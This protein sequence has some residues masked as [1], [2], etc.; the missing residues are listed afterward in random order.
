MFRALHRVQEPGDFL[1]T[2]NN[3]EFLGLTAGWDV[4]FDNPRPLEGDGIDKPVGVHRDRN[5]TGRRS[6]LLNQVNLPSSY[7]HLSQLFGWQAEMAGEPG[8]LLDVSSL[9]LWRRL[10]I[11][12]PLI[13]R[14]R[15]RVIDNSST[16]RTAP[17][18]AAASSRG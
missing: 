12:L 16:K 15:S 14:R 5:R 4:V 6:P 8:N 1:R 9:R 10:R 13:M 2:G 17:H 18:G 11:R 3:G 7:L